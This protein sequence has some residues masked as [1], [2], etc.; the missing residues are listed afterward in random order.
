MAGVLSMSTEVIL[1]VLMMTAGLVISILAI[2][3]INR[4]DKE[5]GYSGIGNPFPFS[6]ILYTLGILAAMLGGF[7]IIFGIAV[8][9]T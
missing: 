3:L 6:G 7:S 4:F 5:A 9:L 8:I 1:G 2:W